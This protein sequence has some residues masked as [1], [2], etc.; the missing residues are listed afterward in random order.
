MIAIIKAISKASEVKKEQ[1]RQYAAWTYLTSVASAEDIYQNEKCCCLQQ[2]I[3]NPSTQ[4]QFNECY[5][6]SIPFLLQ[7]VTFIVGNKKI[8]R[9]KW[10]PPMTYSIPFLL[11][12][13]TF[14]VGNKKIRCYKWRPPMTMST[15]CSTLPY[16]VTNC[17]PVITFQLCSAVLWHLKC[18]KL[19]IRT[20]KCYNLTQHSQALPTADIPSHGV[21]CN[22][23]PILISWT[24]SNINGTQV[25]SLQ[26]NQ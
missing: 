13:V 15:D 16:L 23:S 26:E 12:A 11:Q 19:Y 21:V 22:V 9:Y 25:H 14:I 5:T 17:F 24:H 3:N 2:Y 1:Y 20:I 6:Y 8:R 10:R 7:A 4:L 18:Y